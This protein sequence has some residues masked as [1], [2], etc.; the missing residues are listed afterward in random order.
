MS[1]P[2]DHVTIEILSQARILGA[3]SGS[4]ERQGW[5]TLL[6]TSYGKSR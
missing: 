4:R 1:N 2:S 5:L 3:Y 6:L